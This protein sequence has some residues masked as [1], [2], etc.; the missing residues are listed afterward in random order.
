MQGLM[1][2]YPL[3][4]NNILEYGNLLYPDKKIITKLPNGL[5]HEYQYRDFYKRVKKL[6][7]VLKNLG[8]ESG[9]RVG[10]LSWNNYQHLECYYAIPCMGAVIHTINI[11]LSVEQLTYIINHAE[12][13][14]IIVDATLIP[15]LEKI[16]DQIK[17]VKH[18]IVF[19]TDKIETKIPNILY[20]E[21]LLS[22]EVDD[23]TWDLQDEKQAM[24]LCYTSGTTGEPKGVLYSHRSMYLHTVAQSQTNSL[25]LNTR[26]IVMPVVPMFH[27]MCWG[28][29]YSCIMS[30]T[31]IVMPGPHLKPESLAQLIEEQKIT[32]SAG[33]PTIWHGLYHELKNN[34]RDTSSMRYS[35][36]GGSAMPR[37]LIESYENDLKIKVLHAWGMTETSPLGTVS[38]LNENHED[39]SQEEQFNYKSKQGYPICG[40]EIRI[41]DDHGKKL[42][43]DGETMGELQVRGSWVAKSYYKVS[44]N[45]ESFTDD[46]WFRTG[47]VAT[48][49]SDGYM[50][51]TDRTKDLIK[52]GGEWISSVALENE[53]MSYSG[54]LEAA[55][56][57]IPDSE[58]FERPLALVV[59][60]EDHNLTEEQLKAHLAKSFIKFWLPDKI[61]F[62]TEIPKTTV[63]KFDKKEIR[64]KYWLKE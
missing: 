5:I 1:M 48:I 31:N 14:I 3:I 30:G 7:N 61:I 56:I 4:I 47:D 24:G 37:G 50:N 28:L 25:G 10:T 49:T 55:V 8:I 27:A 57:A 60:K 15:L 58:W 52:S 35:L 40:I 32:I 11:R 2:D 53:L 22:K 41:V 19:N 18:F 45:S 13:K 16:Y 39:M 42:V 38:I 6:A 54:V 9:D 20:Y 46:G 12:D 29:P 33:V 26:D 17:T 43:W 64:K 34:P 44:P 51:I 23:Y 21:D 59:A 62:T 63:G 36:V